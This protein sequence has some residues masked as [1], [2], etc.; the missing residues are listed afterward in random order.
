MP[1]DTYPC[2]MYSEENPIGVTHYLPIDPKDRAT[3]IRQL[4]A[5]GWVDS[6]AQLKV[7]LSKPKGKGSK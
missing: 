2:I 5:D 7:G 4:E 6:P 3:E 1:T